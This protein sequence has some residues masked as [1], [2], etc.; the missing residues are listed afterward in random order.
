MGN[1]TS[2]SSSTPSSSA[3]VVTLYEHCDYKGWAVS[4]PIGEY[5]LASL[6]I[7][8]FQNDQ[9]SSLK[10]TSPGISVTLYQH[11]DFTG[12]NK[13]FYDNIR[14]LVDHGFND[15]VSSIQVRSTTSSTSAYTSASTTA[16]SREY[17]SLLNTDIPGDDIKYSDIPFSS[18]K[19]E[20]DNT[21]KC[22]GWITNNPNQ[23]GCWLKND[24]NPSRRFSTTTRSIY[25]LPSVEGKVLPP[26]PPEPP[27]NIVAT[28]Y[29]HCDYGG[30]SLDLSPGRYDMQA[31][32]NM[33]PIN[34]FKNDQTSS[35]KILK[36]GVKVIL[37]E[38]NFTGQSKIFTGPANIRCLVDHRFNDTVSS[39]EVIDT[40]TISPDT[41]VVLYEHCDYGG[42]SVQLPLGEYDMNQLISKQFKNDQVSSLKILKNKIKITL[43][44]HNF[45]GKSLTFTGP[46]N[47]RCLVDYGFN[48]IM[49]SIKIETIPDLPPAPPPE[50]FV[51]VYEHCDY[52]GWSIQLP[53][54]DFKL[55]D[56]EKYTGFKN[57]EASSLKIKDGVKVT[58]YEGTDFSGKSKTFIGPADVKCLV[59]YLFNDTMSSIKIQN[60]SDSAARKKS[61][62][63]L[64]SHIL[65]TTPSER[66]DVGGCSVYYTNLVDACDSGVFELSDAE[67]KNQYEKNPSMYKTIMN[68]KNKLPEPGICKVKLHNWKR[69]D[70]SPLLNAMESGL[71]NRGNPANWAYCFQPIKDSASLQTMLNTTQNASAITVDSSPFTNVFDSD[72]NISYA[73]LA[74]KKLDYR[75]VK[76]DT[77]SYINNNYVDTTIPNGMVGMEI[78]I[79]T[80]IIKKLSFYNIV[81]GKMKEDINPNMSNPS[82]KN[83]FEEEISGRKLLYVPKNASATIYVLVNDACGNAMNRMTASA[84]FNIGDFGIKEKEL[85]YSNDSDTSGTTTDIMNRLDQYKKEKSE[86]TDSRIAASYTS[87]INR[88]TETINIIE[89]RK[90]NAVKEQ[91]PNAIGKRLHGGIPTSLL[92]TGSV[93]YI[94]VL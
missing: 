27:K 1:T 89:E 86:I 61:V 78:D 39:I 83:L 82:Y 17:R 65:S 34:G 12:N 75:N 57:E 52:K 30:W 22:V 76:N 14:C 54:G 35:L 3:N 10:I 46:T 77:C 16:I 58:V 66:L 19:T 2:T 28:I 80:M 11:H 32:L 8:G 15:T 67:I 33:K 63:P 21:P 70:N 5:N 74:F 42:W 85:Y 59:D 6:Q 9:L 87:I 62:F 20:C 50:Y 51:T 44:E 38:H 53:I 23:R 40:P 60:Y 90:K 29:E 4:L 25:Y 41:V 92:S 94:Q 55:V 49:S 18:C 69:T 73:R 47:I 84:N 13:T 91:L 45:T 88:L 64:E 7:M 24:F 81:N 31:L 71:E 79:N 72:D 68:E 26:A 36:E 93:L 48:D 56:L 37:Y 43:Y